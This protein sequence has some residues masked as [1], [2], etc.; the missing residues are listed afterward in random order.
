MERDFLPSRGAGVLK[1]NHLI[2]H[3]RSLCLLETFPM[4]CDITCGNMELRSQSNLIGN[5]NFCTDLYLLLVLPQ[6]L[7][8]KSMPFCPR[9]FPEKLLRN[10]GA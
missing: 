7:N 4:D 2:W 6:K 8:D 10:R 5:C 9:Y 1:S 3:K